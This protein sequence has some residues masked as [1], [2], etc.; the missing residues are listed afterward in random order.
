MH[1]RYAVGNYVYGTY[2]VDARKRATALEVGRLAWAMI[3]VR[4]R[5]R[6]KQPNF[7]RQHPPGEPGFPI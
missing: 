5:K 7:C 6:T 4:G 1:N 3:A 2:Y